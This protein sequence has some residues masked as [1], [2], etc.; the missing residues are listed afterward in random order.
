VR[1][2]N[3]QEAFVFFKHEVEGKAPLIAKQFL[4]LTGVSPLKL[5]A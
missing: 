5:A 3:W 1:G 2:Q 4:D